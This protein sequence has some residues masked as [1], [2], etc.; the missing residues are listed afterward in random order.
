[1]KQYSMKVPHRTKKRF[2]KQVT[3]SNSNTTQPKKQ[4]KTK[5]TTTKKKNTVKRNII[6]FNARYSKNVVMKV[7]HYFLKLLDKHFPRQHKLHKIF[8]KNTVKASYSCTKNIKS[9][10]SS[11]N[12]KILH[13][14][15]PCP[16][17]QKCNCIKKEFRPLNGNC[18]IENIV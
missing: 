16:K 7:G 3:M 10:I 12:K 9:I 15:W 13:Q 18:Q 2:P 17:E 5:Q 4:N 11:S 1:M 14:N 8:N 6:W